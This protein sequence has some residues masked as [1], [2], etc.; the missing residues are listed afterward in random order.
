[1]THEHDFSQ[2]IYEQRLLVLMECDDGKFR[3]ILLSP[4]Q[5]KKVSDATISERP[6][7]QPSDLRENMELVGIKINEDWEMNADAFIGLTSID[8]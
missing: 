8:E 2:E 6:D 7:V 3:Q 1:M 5:F 4:Q